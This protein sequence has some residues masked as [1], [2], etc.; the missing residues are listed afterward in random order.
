MPVTTL[1]P[2]SGIRA[3]LAALLVAICTSVSLRADVILTAQNLNDAL[4]NMARFR[5]QIASG[6]AE[7]QAEAVFGLGVEA[8]MLATLLSDE[9]I[10]HGDQEK[11]LIDLA[12]ERTREMA[13]AIAY[14]REKQRF[15]YDAAA[16]RDYLT[17]APKGPRAV[18]ARFKVIESEFY[19]S[20]GSDLAAVLNAARSKTDFLAANPKFELNREVHLMLAI[21]YRDLYRLY[22]E[23]GNAVKRQEYG[24]LVRREYRTILRRFPGTEEADIAGKL[25]AR[26]DKEFEGKR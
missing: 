15:F 17:R 20:A 13:I 12:L 3:G 2:S 18:L 9:V 8:E 24:E 14:S 10:A 1:Q 4:K 11:A 26:F 5:K 19:Q 25:L 22:G 16:F 21:D 7:A 23:H 6:T